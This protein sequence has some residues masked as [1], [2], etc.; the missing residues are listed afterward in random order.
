LDTSWDN[1]RFME[2]ALFQARNIRVSASISGKLTK[3]H[4][5]EWFEFCFFPKHGEKSTL[6]ADSWSAYYDR[7]NI[8][9]VNPDGCEL[10]ILT[11]PAGTP[12]IQP[13]DKY[14]F[15]PLKV[16]VRKIYRSRFVRQFGS[17]F[18]PAQQHHQD[19]VPGF[20]QINLTAVLGH[21]HLRICGLWV[22]GREA[23]EIQKSS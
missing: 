6:L 21:N 15:R 19:A 14:F 18:T 17:E 13:L 20:S 4:L 5:R 8:D 3:V 1:C 7:L 10:E 11:I 2:K 23:T 9:V 16:Y 12:N 22:F